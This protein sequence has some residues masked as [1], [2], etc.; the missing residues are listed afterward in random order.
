MKITFLGHAGA[1]VE[2][3]GV[4]LVC[5]PWFSTGGAFLSGW[6]QLP[7]NSP[8]APLTRG[9]THVYV[10]HDHQDHFDA[11]V[12][13]ALDP[14]VTLLMPAYP[15]PSWKRLIGALRGPAPVLLGDREVFRAG[16]LRLR[17]LHSPTPR[18]Q[19]SALV[20]EDTSTGEV[21][22]NL[23]DCQVDRDQLL[24][25]R[26]LHPRI[27]V[28]MAQFSGA[29]W[30]PF[31]YS[32]PERDRVEAAKR[33]K[34][35]SMRRWTRYMRALDPRRAVAFAG[36]PALLDPELAGH[37]FAESSVFTTPPELLAWLRHEHPDLA[38]RT[39]APLPGDELDVFTGVSRP[40]PKIREEFDW[41]DLPAY[42]ADYARRRA[43][44][45]AEVLAA[46][47]EP[48]S[49]LYDDF[50]AHFAALFAAGGSLCR[51]V[52]AVVAFDVRGRGGGFWLVD[53]RSLRVREGS[54]PETDPHDYRFTLS[55]R[56]LPDILNGDT[57]WE[58][59]FFSFRFQA[60]RPGIAAYNEELMS[61]LRCSS[62]GDLAAYLDQSA[63]D[64]AR[65]PGTF[66]LGTAT[67][68]YLVPDACP[69]LGARLGP[70]DYDPELQS[71]VCPQ[72]GWRFALPGG[73]CSNGRARLDVTPVD[74]APDTVQ[75]APRHP[76]ERQEQK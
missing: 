12:L 53:F 29:T 16:P 33:K 18:H 31:A 26:R 10:S 71:I 51:A 28:V 50:A 15:L 20:I 1:L 19:D 68:T 46:R 66:R 69:H 59:F 65:E 74:T 30:F 42:T 49:S 67:G 24:A 55:S 76:S 2:A 39:V 52:D 75:G 5:D 63:P 45:I 23:N 57:S 73:A 64:R 25:I 11:E 13:N 54:G 41:A 17:L 27:D 36:P 44:A 70:Q 14:S 60:W 72:H 8:Y 9:A 4:K 48:R 22:V 40:N 32:F 7:D 38:E 21:V 43:P 3:D 56:F 37:F 34:V 6:H 61:V 47:P 62:P 58:E 35:N